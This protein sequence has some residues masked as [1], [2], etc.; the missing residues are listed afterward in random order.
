VSSLQ[1]DAETAIDEAVRFAEESPEP[2]LEALYEDVY[3]EGN[4]ELRN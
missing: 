1:E 3:K 4:Q 2:P